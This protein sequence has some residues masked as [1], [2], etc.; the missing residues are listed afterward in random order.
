VTECM[1]C[2]VSVQYSIAIGSSVRERFLNN[3]K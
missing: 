1:I 2:R 3:Y